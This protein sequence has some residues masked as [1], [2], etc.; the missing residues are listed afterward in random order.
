MEGFVPI[1]FSF[2][3]YKIRWQATYET[4]IEAEN[5]KEARDGAGDVD[6]D[7]QGSRY[8]EDTWEVLSLEETDS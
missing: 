3:K 6:I 5:L 7:V 1:D 2:M 4:V 8:I